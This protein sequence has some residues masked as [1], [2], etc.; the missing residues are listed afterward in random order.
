MSIGRVR[1]KIKKSER[2]GI[3]AS[4]GS[5]KTMTELSKILTR[6]TSFVGQCLQG[7]EEPRKNQEEEKKR[8]RFIFENV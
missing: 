2:H 7:T 6:R 8:R 5:K 1:K 3:E 4:F